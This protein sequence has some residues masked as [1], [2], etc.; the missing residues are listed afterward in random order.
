MDEISYTDT[1]AFLTGQLKFS[2]TSHL[3]FLSLLVTGACPPCR[4][5]FYCSCQ[6][7][8]NPKAIV[9][10]EVGILKQLLLIRPTHDTSI[11]R[12]F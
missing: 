3:I 1:V 4:H 2:E 7:I 6:E 11:Y 5:T 12:Q 10:G 9:V 8:L